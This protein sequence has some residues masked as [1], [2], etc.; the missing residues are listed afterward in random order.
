MLLEENSY[1]PMPQSSNQNEY[2]YFL[3]N[4]LYEGLLDSTR[5]DSSVCAKTSTLERFECCT[6]NHVHNSVDLHHIILVQVVTECEP[7]QING[8]WRV[9]EGW[10]N[11]ALSPA[12]QALLSSKSVRA[13]WVTTSNT[14]TFYAKDK[15][16]ICTPIP[17]PLFDILIFGVSRFARGLRLNY[18]NGAGAAEPCD[19]QRGRSSGNKSPSSL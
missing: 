12:P 15:S 3:Q 10:F 5:Q 17:R 14:K 9:S 8:R 18:V 4:I 19:G 7:R 16:L 11:P 1:C 13:D 2:S 6:R